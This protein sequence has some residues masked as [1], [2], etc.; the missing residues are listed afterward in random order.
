MINR[1]LL[2]EVEDLS[3]YIHIPFCKK[4]CEY[5]D[6]YSLSVDKML[7]DKYFTILRSELLKLNK[8]WNREYRTI[9]FGGGN[10]YLIGKENLIELIDAAEEFGKSDELTI[11]MNPENFIEDSADLFIERAD[12]VSLGIE[13]FDSEIL[14]L[15]GRNGSSEE[16]MLSLEKIDQNHLYEKMNLDLITSIPIESSLERSKEDLYRIIASK[17]SHISL[18]SLTLYE[19]TPL[20]KR[21]LPLDDNIESEIL[22]ELWSILGENGYDHYEISNFSIGKAKRSKH[23]MAYWNLSSFIGLGPTSESSLGYRD[24]IS[25]RNTESIE[26][27]ISNPD[28][29]IDFLERKEALTEYIM[30]SLRTSDGISKSVL[31]DRFSFDMDKITERLSREYGRDYISYDDKSLFLTERGMLILDQIVL[32]SI[33]SF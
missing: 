18:Y 23:N 29:Q 12:R 6:F 17:V 25:M 32:S 14:S 19:N 16:N 2:K 30:L 27:Y 26:D 7:R 22:S 3:L 10:P 1:S 5:C 33:L 20:K 31:S 21:V 11:E 28:Y 8:I 9:Y 15:I 24:V 4:K 13:S